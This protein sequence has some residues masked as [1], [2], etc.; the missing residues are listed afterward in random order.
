MKRQLII[1]CF[2]ALSVVSCMKHSPIEDNSLKVGY[3]YCS[4]GTA[5]STFDYQNSNSK[6][7]VGIVFW[8]NENS[9]LTKDKA[10][11]IA[12]EDIP[13]CT[14][15]DSL[16][17]VGVSTNM[18]T[19]DGASNTATMIV[20]N[21]TTHVAADAFTKSYNYARYN[22]NN[23]YL[24]SVAEAYH[25]YRNQAIITAAIE[26][27]GGTPFQHYWYWTSTQDGTNESATALNAMVIDFNNGKVLPSNKQN[28][29][30]V[31][32]IISIK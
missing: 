22:I 16:A 14:W 30:A 17:D 18:R 29:F 2:V 21:A 28:Y 15:C 4:D 32:P 23:W 6:N 19:F 10:L 12:L 8:V 3:I 26:G 25:I 13:L 1:S 5:I 7:A 20:L 27:C 11:I 9:N 24:P 31:R